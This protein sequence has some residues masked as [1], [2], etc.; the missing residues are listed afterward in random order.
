MG[1]LVFKADQVKKLVDHALAA[2][3]HRD[4]YDMQPG[5][6][7]YLVGDRG[8]YLMSSGMPMLQNPDAPE[9]HHFVAYAEGCN[10]DVDDFDTWWENKRDL[11]GGDDASSPLEWVENIDGLI[12]AGVETIR[13]KITPA[14]LELMEG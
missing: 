14:S 5:M 2:P 8:V 11:F 7:L 6:A 3:G 10:P 9:G 4:F 1:I 12:K 13:I